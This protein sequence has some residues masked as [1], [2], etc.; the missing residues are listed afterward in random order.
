LREQPY[1]RSVY[2]DGHS[3]HALLPAP[4]L[5]TPSPERT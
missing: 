2:I 1:K 5:R 4:K 3:L